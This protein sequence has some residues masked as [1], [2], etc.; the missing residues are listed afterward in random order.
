MKHIV[1]A[2]LVILMLA[3]CFVTVFMAGAQAE[4]AYQTN[5]Q[6]PERNDEICESA[7]MAMV[8]LPIVAFIVRRH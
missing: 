8:V 4:A 1:A 7:V 2:G 6:L 5:Q 3:V